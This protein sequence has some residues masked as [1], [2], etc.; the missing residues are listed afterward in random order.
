MIATLRRSA[1]FQQFIGDG[2]DERLKGRVDDIAADTDRG[3]A[4]TSFI[5]GFNEN[6]RDGVRPALKHTDFIIDDR[7][8]FDMTL[9]FAE[10][11]AQSEIK[12]V[13]G[14]IAFRR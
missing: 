6:A 7:E 4:F 9:I 1:A 5:G 3:P 2:I 11:F 14:A 8:R 12:R 10:I 13:D